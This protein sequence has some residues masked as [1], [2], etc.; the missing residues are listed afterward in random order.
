MKHGTKQGRGK[1]TA[2]VLLVASNVPATVKM[3]STSSNSEYNA[4]EH[5]VP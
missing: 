1:M 5:P 4:R 3:V 2:I